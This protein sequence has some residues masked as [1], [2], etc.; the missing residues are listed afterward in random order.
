MGNDDEDPAVN[1]AVGMVTIFRNLSYLHMIGGLFYKLNFDYF[2]LYLK[3][4]LMI[5]FGS[6]YLGDV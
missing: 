6:I 2:K 1:I 3:S 5:Y 4:T